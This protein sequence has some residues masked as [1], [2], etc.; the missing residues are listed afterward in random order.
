MIVPAT[1]TANSVS[2]SGPN[3]T[4]CTLQ[5]TVPP[6]TSGIDYFVTVTTPGGTSAY[7]APNSGPYNYV[8]YTPVTPIVASISGATAGSITGGT[9]VTINGP[10]NGS[11]GF[12]SAPNFQAQV[13]FCTALPC[14]TTGANPTAFLASHVQVISSSTMTALSPQVN[15][16]SSATLNYFVQVDTIG[17]SSINTTDSFDYGLQVPIIFSLSPDYRWFGNDADDQ[18]LQFPAQFHCGLGARQ[19]QRWNRHT[20]QRRVC[21]DEHNWH[22]DQGHG[23]DAADRQHDLYPGH[24][25]PVPL[26]A[27]HLS[28]VAAI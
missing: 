23:S 11:G 27:S 25:G 12:Y 4:N 20:H 17:G 15:A 16:P 3:N 26:H 5:V 10:A 6:V 22:S 28:L 18:R 24:H 1:V 7:Q 21:H 2:C 19:C 14:I 8:A 13:L 9:T